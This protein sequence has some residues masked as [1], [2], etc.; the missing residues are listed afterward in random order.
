MQITESELTV[1][2]NFCYQDTIMYDYKISE[3]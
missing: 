3:D 2:D 1:L